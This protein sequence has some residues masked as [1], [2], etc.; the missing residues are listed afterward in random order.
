MELAGLVGG[1]VR[2]PLQ[3]PNEIAT[4]EITQLLRQA[5]D[6][7]NGDASGETAFAATGASLAQTAVRRV[8]SSSR[9]RPEKLS[10]TEIACHSTPEQ[11]GLAC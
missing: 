5:N 9:Q 8:E 3:R 10:T 6:A 4:A 7:V 11:A 2:A 1:P